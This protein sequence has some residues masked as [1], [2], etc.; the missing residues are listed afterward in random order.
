MVNTSFLFYCSPVHVVFF[1]QYRYVQFVCHMCD[2]KRGYSLVPMPNQVC[3]RCKNDAANASESEPPPIIRVVANEISLTAGSVLTLGPVPNFAYTKGK[4]DQ[5]KRFVT[6]FDKITMCD[7][8]RRFS[9]LTV[10]L[11]SFDSCVFCCQYRVF[12][13]INIGAEILPAFHE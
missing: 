8:M 1:R 2:G 5:I 13:R 4:M 10:W 6:T 12:F 9:G 11:V 3:Q 7:P